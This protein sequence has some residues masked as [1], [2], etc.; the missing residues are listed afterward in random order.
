MKNS[1]FKSIIII[2]AII[3]AIIS[4]AIVIPLLSDG[5]SK[6]NTSQ[7]STETVTPEDTPGTPDASSDTD[8]STDIADAV[9]S[10]GNYSGILRYIDIDSCTLTLYLTESGEDMEFT[11]N[12]GTCVKT[13]YD[14]VISTALL[15]P[16]DFLDV[17]AGSNGHLSS[18]CGSKDMWSYKDILKISIDPELHRIIVGSDYYR[19]DDRILVMSGN[20]F[21]SLEDLSPL[22]I[23][24]IYGYDNYV[25]LIKVVSG[26]G[27]LSLT[28][29]SDFV[30][31][32]LFINDTAVAQITDNMVWPL[33]EGDYSVRVENLELSASA[34]IRINTLETSSFDLTP[35]SRIPV[36]YG[37]ADF[38]IL[39]EGAR[40][41][42]DGIN[43]FYGE[44]VELALGT[45]SIRV[46]LGGYT[47]FV[48]T[49]NVGR[50]ENSYSISLPPAPVADAPEDILYNY[51]DEDEAFLSDDNEDEDDDFT[52][53]DFDDSTSDEDDDSYDSEVNSESSDSEDEVQTAPT[54]SHSGDS[55]IIS[56][57]EGCSIY[58]DDVYK[59]EVKN[60][61][62]TCD[63]PA[64][65]PVTIRL[66]LAGYITRTYTVT[67][68]DDGEDAEFSFP[69]MVKE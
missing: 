26:H 36:E 9:K 16:G 45:H 23:L 38:T 32:N 53:V 12:A 17:T 4:A 52:D 43:T 15:K 1:Q 2:T 42:V 61:S 54:G 25:Y 14:R 69:D 7:D 11:F 31:G 67:I 66:T 62:I 49:I 50:D 65:G 55:M 10:S 63:K 18:I 22:D 47:S 41:F 19:W 27:F 64:P 56:C 48:G 30:G 24:S 39:P 46:E 29:A 57:T 37:T 3:L 34:D 68:E 51:T 5:S 60:G 21:I 20:S 13:A 28:G 33:A 59:G 35:Y 8:T 58:V 6:D 40:L 44:T